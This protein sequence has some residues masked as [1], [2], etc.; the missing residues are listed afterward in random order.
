MITTIL[1]CLFAAVLSGGISAYATHRFWSSNYAATNTSGDF[2]SPRGGIIVV[3][4]GSLVGMYF[5]V[6]LGKY[7]FP[8][9]TISPAMLTSMISGAVGGF[10]T[11]FLT[12]RANKKQADESKDEPKDKDEGAK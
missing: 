7:I 11:L 6:Y 1:V 12:P 2:G 9:E 10:V 8:A 3:L 5:F 4:L